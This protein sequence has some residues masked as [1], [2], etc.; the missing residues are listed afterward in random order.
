MILNDS[1]INSGCEKLAGSF[2]LRF[3]VRGLGFTSQDLVIPCFRGILFIW[4]PAIETPIKHLLRRNPFI[5]L[6][7]IQ[8]VKEVSNS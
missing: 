8:Q 2:S 7:T 4:I 6:I 3:E 1:A 5:V